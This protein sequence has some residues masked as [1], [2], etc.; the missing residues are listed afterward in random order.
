MEGVV[1]CVVQPKPLD[2]LPISFSAIIH[3]LLSGLVES[4]PHALGSNEREKEPET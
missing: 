2:G 3:Q 1:H 4:V